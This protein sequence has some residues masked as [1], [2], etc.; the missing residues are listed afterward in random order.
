MKLRRWSDE[1][2]AGLLELKRRLAVQLESIDQ[3]PE[4]VGDRKLLRFFRGHNLDIEKTTEMVS[5][6]IEW[7]KINN[8]DAIR[9]EIVHGK[10][11]SFHLLFP[12]VLLGHFSRWKKSSIQISKW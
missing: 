9:S 1:E 5:K 7:R 8:V 11:A 12:S 2:A 6:F 3:N 10:I 4:V